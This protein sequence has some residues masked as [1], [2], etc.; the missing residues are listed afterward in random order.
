MLIRKRQLFYCSNLGKRYANLG[1]LNAFQFVN[2]KS[3][4]TNIYET[5]SNLKIL[6]IL[7]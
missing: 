7:M 5:K 4:F 2:I 6:I 1:A 3:F